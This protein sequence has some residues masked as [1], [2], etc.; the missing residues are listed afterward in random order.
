MAN[1]KA[2]LVRRSQKVAFYGVPGTDG[3]EPEEFKRMEHFTSLSESKN[4]ETYERKYVDKDSK[5]SDVTGYG[6]ALDYAF[7][8]HQNDPVLKDIAAIHDDELMGEV[9]TLVTVDLFNKGDATAENEYVARKRGFSILPD[10]SGDGTD[11]LQYS[12]SFAVKT[13]SVK[14]YAKVSADGKTC[15]FSEKPSEDI[16]A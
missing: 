5:D 14:G 9:R 15:T 11:A 4:P 1:E 12:G 13:E 7:D 2:N 16:G 8:H 6:T 10:S 3:A